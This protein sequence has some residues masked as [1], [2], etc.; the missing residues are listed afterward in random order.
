M[1]P[2]KIS[3]IS[4]FV[5]LFL[6]SCTEDF[7]LTE[8]YKNIPVIYALINRT[9]TAQYFRIQKA[10][11]DENIPA[12]QIA[13]NPDSLYYSNPTVTLKNL[14]TRKDYS[15]IKVDGNAE[16]I[17]R[18]DGPFATTPNILYKLLTREKILNGGDSLLLELKPSDGSHVITS[19]IVLVSDI[20][21]VFPDENTRQFKIFYNSSYNFQWKHK[22]N[23]RV[24]DLKAI[25]DI[26]E[27]NIVTLKTEKKII[28]IPI[29]RNVFGNI[30]RADNLTSTKIFGSTF[31]VFFND[32]LSPDPAI[33]RYINKIDF[34]LLG[35]GPEIGEY[36]TI[37]NANTGITASQEIP[38]Y[39]NISEGFGIFSSTIKIV[40]TITAEPP[41]VDSLRTN[42][43][44]RQL[45]FK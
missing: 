41:T 34:I 24:F 8:P 43:L 14:T 10:Y 21:Y 3:I 4:L 45:N 22:D 5:V 25:V 11:V 20:S 6:S 28:E 33:E 1:N 18:N 23:T 42:P 38:R 15:L 40:K 17:I 27:F 44:T 32:K 30:G 26:D 35:G 36:N 2:S 29:A 13:K 19:R 39:T 7:Q 9:D 16:G 12:T 31:Y 37:L